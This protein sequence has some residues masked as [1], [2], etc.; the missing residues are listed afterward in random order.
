MTDGNFLDTLTGKPLDDDV[1]HFAVPVI[2]PF[3][4]VMSYKVSKII[5]LYQIT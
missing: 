2:A 3:A 4:S 5:M 1:V